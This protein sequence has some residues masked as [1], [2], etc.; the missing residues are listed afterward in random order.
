[1]QDD[2]NLSLRDKLN[3]E[4]AKI[5]WRALQRFFAAGQAL[6]LEPGHDLVACACALAQDDVQQIKPLMESN[7][8][9][10]V[11]DSVAQA[12]YDEDEV[13]WAVVVKP[14]V[15]VQSQSDHGRG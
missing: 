10:R 3:R 7:V 13:L 15:L 1:M 14:W 2:A 6:E 8:L 5:E 11:P 9:R 4:T 12:W